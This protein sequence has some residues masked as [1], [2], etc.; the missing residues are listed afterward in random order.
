MTVVLTTHY[1]EEADRVCDRVGI[2]DRGEIV[3]EGTPAELKASLRVA[4]LEDVYL[5]L[6]GRSFDP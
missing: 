5:R 6:T 4:T 1:M 2:V 3:V